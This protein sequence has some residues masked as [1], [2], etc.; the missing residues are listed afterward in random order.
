MNMK[1]NILF[2]DEWV[3]NYW[4]LDK[5]DKTDL[6]KCIHLHDETQENKQNTSAFHR[7]LSST[8]AWK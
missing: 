8:D 6:G 7:K 5:T 2:A 3:N 1:E 4:W